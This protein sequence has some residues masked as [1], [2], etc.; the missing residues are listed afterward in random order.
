MRLQT[1]AS[2]GAL[3]CLI[4]P[5]PAE[6]QFV[7]PPNN[8]LLLN[9]FGDGVQI[10][11]SQLRSDNSG[12]Y[13]WT[14]I[15]PSATLFTDSTEATRIGLHFAGPTWQ[16]DSDSSSVIGLRI[17]S[18]PSPNPNSIPQLLLSAKAYG[19][20]GLLDEVSYIERLNTVG[21]LA[22]LT[23][24]TGAGQEFR[25]PYTATYSFFTTV[26]E[27]GTM[28]LVLVSGLMGAVLLRY[29]RSS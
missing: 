20:N 8:D 26:P 23:D 3:A 1:L 6:A 14:F 9:S 29:R 19:G 10:Y 28:A 11:Q 5:R 21:G 16:L 12:T 24:P 25:S 27:P 17:A 22:P 15:A 4:C 18:A 2:L 7:L 13:Q